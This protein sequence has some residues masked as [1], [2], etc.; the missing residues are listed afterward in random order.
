MFQNGKANGLASYYEL[1]GSLKE[2]GNY[3]DGKRIGKW[4]FYLDG[5]IVDDKQKKESLKNNVKNQN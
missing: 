5:E 1:S 3:K 2:R 4:E